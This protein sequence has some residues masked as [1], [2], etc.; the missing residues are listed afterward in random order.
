[1]YGAKV[2][3]EVNE[4]LWWMRKIGAAQDDVK[5]PRLKSRIGRKKSRLS[6]Y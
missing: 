3:D 1:M 2:K 5:K 6:E 4:L